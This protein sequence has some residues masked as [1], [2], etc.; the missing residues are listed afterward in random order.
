MYPIMRDLISYKKQWLY[1]CIFGQCRIYSIRINVLSQM[2][3]IG[4][5]TGGLSP[6]ISISP[7]KKTDILIKKGSKMM[8]IKPTKYKI[9][10][11]KGALPLTN[12]QNRI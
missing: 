8:H 11:G 1:F 4:L 9:F 10:L 12:P 3:S 5:G 6:S 2:H 7:P